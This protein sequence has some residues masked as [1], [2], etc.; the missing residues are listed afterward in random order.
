MRENGAFWHH[1]RKRSVKEKDNVP[2]NENM[3]K[4]R[5]FSNWR[6]NATSTAILPQNVEHFLFSTSK[7]LLFS[8]YFYMGYFTIKGEEEGM[9][10]FV[11][12]RPK[13]CSSTSPRVA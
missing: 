6:M 13:A 12:G 3:N 5:T 1:L 8:I 10:V 4:N 7:C 2:K 11:Y 9:S